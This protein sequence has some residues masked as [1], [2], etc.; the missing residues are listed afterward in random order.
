MNKFTNKLKGFFGARAFSSAS[1]TAVVIAVVVVLNAVLYALTSLF[2]LYIYSPETD[3]LSLSGNTDDLFAEALDKKKE[4]TVTFLKTEQDVQSHETGSFVLETARAFAERYPEM[5]SLRFVNFLTRRD[6][7]GELVNLSKYKT[8]M[9]GNET[10]LL[11]SSVIFSCGEN[12]RVITDVYTSAGYADFFTI[13]GS[14]K[15]NAYN[16]EEVMGAMISWV[17]HDEHKTAYLTQNHGET[18][19][20]AFSNLLACAGYYVD[21]INLRKEEVPRDKAGMVIISNPTT[22]F[23]RAAEGSDVRAEIERLDDYLADGG[24]LYVAIDPY[25]RRLPVLEGYLAEKGITL[26]GRDNEIGY[27]RDVVKDPND[28]ISVDGLT[29]V[30]EFGDNNVASDIAANVKRYSDSKVLLSTVSALELSGSAKPLL[31]SSPSSVLVSGGKTVDSEGRYPVAAYAEQANSNGSYA[32]IFVIP[33]SLLTES[34]VLIT[35]GYANKDFVY[36]TFVELF[37]APSAPY[38]CKTV[39]YSTGTLEN[40]TMGKAKAYTALLM[41]VPAVL[42]VLGAVY[43]IRRKNR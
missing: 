7:N 33:S 9:N 25:V 4:V 30:A 29:F 19:D 23:E 32:H 24:K 2:G 34:D 37:G 13:D 20:V 17:L 42:G 11:S 1:L 31:L 8:D 21:V 6:E 41:A 10:A 14:G 36:S 28:A 22:D 26:M 15:A 16:G 3:D 38:G 35:D 5:I 40:L 27:N 43:I 12:Y 39:L 18:A